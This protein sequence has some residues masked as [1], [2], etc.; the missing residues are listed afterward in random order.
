LIFFESFRLAA[1]VAGVAMFFAPAGLLADDPA[2]AAIYQQ[3]CARC[4]GKAGEGA[5]EHP[6]PLVGN[7]SLAQ[8][9]KYISKSM[10]EDAPGTVV[11]PDAE[12][13]AGYI[14]HA[15]YSPAAQAKIKAPR[16]ELSR[17]TV[18]EYRNA[19]ADVIGSF[20][21]APPAGKGGKQ[22][23]DAKSDDTKGN[24]AKDSPR[25]ENRPAAGL[26]GDYFNSVK[27]A[28]TLAFSR[29]DPVVKVNFGDAA[30]EYE[31]LKTEELAVNWTGSVL[32]TET[33]LYD[34]IVHTEHSMKLF[35]NDLRKP[36][37][38]AS[39]KSGSDTEFKAPIYLLAGRAYPLRLE[40]N[41]GAVGV[42]KD[43]QDKKKQ[44]KT[45]VAL[46]WKPPHRAAG[47]IP[48]RQLM[49]KESE[50]S[51][52]L[53]IAV[54]PDDKSAG[55]ERG[56]AVSKAWVQATTDG[57]IEAANFVT[58]N[59]SELSGVS[60]QAD[61]RKA[62][63][64]E[65]C[66][67]FV[68]R[69]FRRP[70]TEEQ[71]RLY[72]E[73][74]FSA[75]DDPEIAV[76]R[77][78]LLTLQSPRFLYREPSGAADAFDVASRL[79][80]ALWDTLPD[81]EL[82]KAAAA[83]RLAT[84]DDVVRE[85]ERMLADRRARGKINGFFQQWL[86][87][88]QLA[89]LPKDA[90]D[91]PSFNAVVVADLHTSLEL[92]LEDVVWSEASDFRQ[93]LLADDLYLNG[94][95]SALYG[96]DL[97]ADAPFQKVALKSGDRA[98]VLTHPLLMANFSYTSTS[99]PIH[100][101]VFLARNILG[102]ALRQPPDAFT[103]LPPELH[104]NL[105][106][107]ERIALQTSPRD[108]RSCH[109]IVN[110]LGFTLERYD[111]IGRLRD[112]EK[113]KPIDS[114]GGFTTR[115]GDLVKF[116]G[117]SD[118]AKFVAGSDEAHEAFVAR[119]FHHL[120]KQP[121]L[122]YG[123]EKLNELRRSFA[124]NEFNIRRL[125]VEIVVQTALPGCGKQATKAANAADGPA[126]KQ[127]DEKIKARMDELRKKFQPAPNLPGFKFGQ[128]RP[129]GDGEANLVVI[130]M[131]GFD[132]DTVARDLMKEF[133]ARPGFAAA[134]LPDLGSVIIQA[135]AKTMVEATRFL[136]FRKTPC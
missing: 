23:G 102:V 15:F 63:L 33:G 131:K 59:L 3:K 105:T 52:A 121:V 44:V 53:A 132:L 67:K 127:D 2:G 40:F 94:R 19:V 120:V 56:N 85:A 81:Q 14:F 112:E 101:G 11:G 20:R 116:R 108:C 133:G 136:D 115:S 31:K 90:K 77:V 69:A 13:V 55:Y 36:L 12:K 75:T 74:Q 107:R 60:A 124:E 47:L 113:G 89:D 18:N 128:P 93:L 96:G 49:P 86:K 5:K 42:R 22:R 129:K 29:V 70:L 79:S 91:F 9:T 103:P 10:P 54:P 117:A 82:I 62:K 45:T 110:P 100:R 68:E 65:Y 98:G 1:V 97:P 106:T 32:P 114:T 7:R 64:Q 16:V 73:R 66:V 37:I 135:D 84:R 41:R 130:P 4:H 83:G 57:A 24:T 126:P 119:L 43:D 28:R 17:L 92:F 87:V 27:R 72:V 111:A 80:F 95:L 34:F 122:A 51:F 38:D 25:D 71:K 125:V 8:L 118:L 48:E 6:Q 76:R 88:D 134:A 30:P 123:P 109:G 35:V 78:V 61:G 104:P 46:E 58:A 21:T 39:V 50:T 26:R 99:S